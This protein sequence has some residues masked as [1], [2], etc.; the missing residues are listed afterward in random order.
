MYSKD[1]RREE[2]KPESSEGAGGC[3]SAFSAPITKKTRGTGKF[4]MNRDLFHTAV[5][6][7][8]SKSRAPALRR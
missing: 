5:E 2:M 8:D 6:A 4:I 3:L 1:G 7:G